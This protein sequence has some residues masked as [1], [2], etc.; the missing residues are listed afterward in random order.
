[1]KKNFKLSIL[2][3][4]I[5]TCFITTCFITLFLNFSLLASTKTSGPLQAL[6]ANINI[7][8]HSRLTNYS[9][10]YKGNISTLKSDINT[11]INNILNS[12]DY[13]KFTSK[14]S[15]S[16]FVVGNTATITFKFSYCNT[17]TMDS[18]VATQETQILNQIITP[19]MNVYQ[20]EKAIHD[21]IVKNV[22]Y[23]TTLAK[24]SD[25]NALTAPYKTVCQGYALLAYKMLNQVGIQT[26]II[27]GKADGYAH[28]WNEVNLD[29][30]WYHLDCTWDDPVPDIKGTVLYNYY[31]LTD[32]QIKT[33]HAWTGTYP[34]ANTSFDNV[35]N[36]KITSDSTNAKI[37]E[38]LDNAIGIEYLTPDYTVNNASELSSKI[39]QSINNKQFTITVRYMNGNTLAADIKTAI[40]N[41]RNITSFSYSKTPF[42][43]SSEP[44]DVILTLNINN[45][46][47]S[48]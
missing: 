17:A 3:N 6:Q 43:R 18:Y 29:G 9:V 5:V 41:I 12:D 26:K 14:Y 37:Y 22:S 30:V 45:K 19:D 11:V 10:I 38:D 13:L 27:S 31:N 28:A 44:N 2:K 35:L 42:I 25:Y 33:N 7:A 23:D 32:S 1:M 40:S 8:M 20:K 36:K 47:F 21:W 48:N 46:S 4:I 16:Y 34:A 15:Y 24:H 39:Q